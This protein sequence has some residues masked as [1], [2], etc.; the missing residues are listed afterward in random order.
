MYR[1]KS[2]GSFTTLSDS[3]GGTTNPGF[4][5]GGEGRLF[6]HN[7]N[8]YSNDQDNTHLAREEDLKRHT[9]REKLKFAI[10]KH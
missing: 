5:S 7:S 10:C 8:N 3:N 2:Q 9:E 6:R 1:G 4:T